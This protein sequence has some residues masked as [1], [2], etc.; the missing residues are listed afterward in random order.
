M[1]FGVVMFPG[2][3]CDHDCFYA[4]QQ[5]FSDQVDFIWHKSTDV[6]GYDCIVLPGGFS[7]GDYLRTGAIAR[8]SP[9][10]SEVKKFASAGKPVIGI[11]NG[12]QILLESGLL[13]GAM[14][15]N[16]SLR[17]ICKYVHIKPVNFSTP[18]SKGLKKNEA[19]H[20]PVAHGEGNYYIDDEGL[21]KLQKNN[22]IV[23]QYCNERGIVSDDFNPNGSVA[24]IAGICNEAGN[25]LGMMPHPERC[26]DPMLGSS[27]GKRIFES[28]LQSLNQRQTV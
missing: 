6:H 18:F 17:F 8:F 21:K 27:D 14:L 3:N 10:M 20:I 25:V 12:F 15:R 22:Q 11:C 24:N 16:T 9:V 28:L 7:Y 2:S 19:I 26:C 4:V 5:F 13:P 23:F 1:K